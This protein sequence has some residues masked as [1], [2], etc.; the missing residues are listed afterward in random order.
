MRLMT[1]ILM[2]LTMI[3][4]LAS[5]GDLS[6][7]DVVTKPIESRQFNAGCD[8]VVDDFKDIF[9]KRIKASIDCLEKNI[10]LFMRVVESPRPGYLSRTAF[11]QYIVRNV[12]DFPAENVRAIKSVFEISHLLFG[13]DK[14][15]LSP[16][17]VRKIFGILSLVN[18]EVPKIYPYFSSKEPTP[19]NLHDFNKVRVFQAADR[20]SR[21]MLDIFKLDRG[22]QIHRLNIIELLESFISDSTENILAK[23]K[24]VIFIKKV[25]IGGNKEVITHLEL[26]D[27]LFKI[28]PISSVAFDLA[29]VSYLDLDQRT[30]M[31]LLSADLDLIDRLLYY[32]VESGERLFSI[33]D[34]IKAV[35]Y[36][37]SAETKLPDLEKYRREILQAKVLL[38]SEAKWV[39]GEDLSGKDWII[40]QDLK[41]L[42]NHGKDIA[43][44]GS[45]YHRIYKF[46]ETFLESPGPVNI[47]YNNYLLQ[48]PTH[49]K[50][51]R[52]FARI[53]NTHRVFLG[54]FDMPFFSQSFRRNA[55]G[56]VEIGLFEYLFG[57]VSRRYGTAN[58]S[59]GGFGMTLDELLNLIKV[60][61]PVL[62]GEGLIFEGN[63]EKT[64]EN[65]A[66][67]STLF[68]NMSNGDIVINVDEGAA[69]AIQVVGAMKHSDYFETEMGK[70]C[71]ADPNRSCETDSKGRVT[72]LEFYRDNFFEVLCEKFG[73]EFPLLLDSM[74]MKT[75]ADKSRQ[76]L[77]RDYLMKIET[78][79]RSCTKFDDGTDVPVGSDDYMPMMVM[80]MTVEGVV[81]RYDKNK[82]NRLD[83]SEMKTAYN[84]TFYS[85][86]E[87]LVEEQASIIAKL[88]FN[89]G[90]A[91]SRKIYYYLIKHRKIPEKFGEYLKLLTIGP[92]SADRDTLAAVLK[93]ISEQGATS[94]FDCELLR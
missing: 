12:P 48:F 42:L 77:K 85:A 22:D 6:K 40:P 46:F 50:Y 35:P 81:L 82:N 27:L 84:E 39:E 83:A 60:F 15:Y 67:L 14:E 80:L 3:S 17:A 54:K 66:L 20:I 8:L 87:A 63:E 52:E 56:M 79:A 76:S 58:D 55:N 57:I 78:I 71:E 36:F 38:M 74:G 7:S 73:S 11:E 18:E 59:V 75:C 89:L 5:C 24:A 93:I 64:S 19:I 10:D 32:P 31:E 90:S 68:Q 91:V 45:I 4:L 86:I 2:L 25:I 47:N 29:R 28:A 30:L 44:R 26:Q 70:R 92:S 16:G 37:V 72:D 94:T 65:I 49:E 13:E 9:E 34:L 23:T 69:F 61:S 53:A 21:A 51:V 1:K 88:P 33:D 62:I 41:T 43:R